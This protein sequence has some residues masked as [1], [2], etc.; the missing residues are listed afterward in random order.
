MK[1][2]SPGDLIGFSSWTLDGVAINCASLGLPLWDLSHIGIVARHPDHPWPL[3]C[4]STSLYREPCVVQSKILDGVQWH[5]IS[6]RI[7]GYRGLVWHYRLKVPL[8][9]YESADL[10]AFLVEMTG[11]GYDALGAL[12][13]RDTLLAALVRLG[14]AEDLISLFCS[15]LCAAAGRA[16]GRFP[17]VRNA[18]GYSPNRL[19]RKAVCCWATHQRPLWIKRRPCPGFLMRGAPRGVSVGD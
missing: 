6:E 15:E 14:R 7:R 11:R 4:E 9:R 13:A 16:M 17:H 1:P 2:F 12:G 18:S 8:D 10:A 5:K 19:A 3:L